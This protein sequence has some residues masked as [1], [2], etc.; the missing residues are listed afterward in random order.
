[1]NIFTNIKSGLI[2]F[3]FFLAGSVYSQCSLT[4]SVSPQPLPCGD[5]AFLSVTANGSSV[6]FGENF[7]SGQP[8][9]WQFTQ[10][11]T[12]GNNT[13]GVPSLDGSDFMW[14]GSSA[15]YP[16]TMTTNAV[17][18]SCG[19][20]ICFE[21]RYAIQGGAAPCEGPDLPNEGVYLEYSLNNVTWTQINYWPPTNNGAAS[22]PMTQWTQYCETLPA[23]AQ[24][25]AT[26]I[27]WNQ[28]SASNSNFDHWGLDNIGISA[29]TCGGYTVSWQHDGFSLPMGQYTGTNPNGVSP[30]QNT[31]YVVQMT[32]GTITCTDTVNVIVD[33]P[34]VTVNNPTICEGDSVL[35]TASASQPGGTF[36]WSP[37]G[38]TTNSIMVAPNTSSQYTVSYAT[39]VCPPSSTV[40]SVTVDPAPTLSVSSHTIC[41]GDS[42]IITATP[43][44]GGTLP[45]GGTY[46]WNPGGIGPQSMTVSP[47]TNT[48]YTVTYNLGACLPASNTGSVTVNPTPT[49]VVDD[50]TICIGDDAIITCV[51]PLSGQTGGTYDWTTLGVTNATTTVTPS[52]TTDYPVTYTANGCSTTDTATVL[53]NQL[54]DVG[55]TAD[56]TQGCAPF[57]TT[58]TPNIVDPNTTYFWTTGLGTFNG[59][60][61]TP[62]F[63]SGGCYD[64]T[65]VANSNGCVNTGF[66][67]QY[68]CVDNIP[69]ASFLPTE[70]YFYELTQEMSFLNNSAG[71]DSYLW[72]FGDFTTSVEFEP[73]HLFQNT[74]GGFIVSLIAITD[75]GC[76]DTATFA[77]PYQEGIVYYIPNTFTPDGDNFNQE[78]EPVF[79]SGYDPNSFNMKIFNR[80]GEVVFETND[81]KVGWDGTYGINGDAVQ[82]GI[83]SYHISYKLPNTDEKKIVTGHV[84]LLR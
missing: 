61:I 5:T 27:R 14:M 73:T 51:V 57:T 26:Y 31:S 69:D 7:N 62:V 82:E 39:A 43:D 44:Q 70:N 35:L 49:I 32:N 13:C 8:V 2:F 10:S 63:S 56:S 28:A 37:S 40:S 83:Y 50:P 52:I 11:V 45:T 30:N 80:W 16:R 75:L 64:I 9:G 76:T 68:I 79:F 78:F 17:D 34:I 21:M 12:I 48:N 24:T 3:I 29:T 18:L 60:Q 74:T 81:S 22:S 77:I 41:D 1:M 55:F 25:T 4:G 66:A 67:S 15:T 47:N 42:V 46:T 59:P 58:L 84:T 6:V 23:A 36:S 19:G 53:V 54:P 38:Q 71:A 72:D 20:D 65:L 33:A